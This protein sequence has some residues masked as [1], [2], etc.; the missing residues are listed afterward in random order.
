MLYCKVKPSKEECR[1]CVNSAFRVGDRPDCNNCVD[2]CFECRLINV[3]YN[4]T[5]GDWA[6]VVRDGVIERVA[7]DRVFDVSDS[8]VD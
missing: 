6:M 5:I 2:T 7:L 3:G 1:A 4:R 8:C